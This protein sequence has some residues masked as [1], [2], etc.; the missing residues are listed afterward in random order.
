MN[1]QYYIMGNSS[2]E[3]MNSK[4]ILEALN[5]IKNYTSTLVRKLQGIVSICYSGLHSSILINMFMQ[6]VWPKNY[7]RANAV[8]VCECAQSFPD[9]DQHFKRRMQLSSFRPHVPER[10]RVHFKINWKQAGATLR[11]S[12]IPS[13]PR[14]R[15]NKLQ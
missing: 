10:L 9:W 13:S 2:S 7:R 11:T 12:M 6:T 5:I 14:R 4:T 1:T 3:R 8:R 15:N